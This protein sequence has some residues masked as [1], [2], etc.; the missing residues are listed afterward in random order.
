LSDL[1]SDEVRTPAALVG[2]SHS[3]PAA[4]LLR[5][6]AELEA[7]AHAR[8]PVAHVD[9]RL[10]DALDVAMS[11]A[12]RLGGLRVECLR[13]L[14]RH[15]RVAAPSLF[16]GVPSEELGVSVDHV[17]MQAAHE[18]TVVEVGEWAT[19]RLTEREVEYAALLV[20]AT[21]ARRTGFAPVHE[22]WWATVTD[23]SPETLQARAS[24]AVSSAAAAL[25]GES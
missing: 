12:P 19:R 20:L 10:G 8:L 7:S 6:A 13:S 1:R 5:A 18:A 11:V 14:G 24:D 22:A 2:L 4:E 3:W 21:R 16:V 15:G 23:V 17:A 25:Q 9:P